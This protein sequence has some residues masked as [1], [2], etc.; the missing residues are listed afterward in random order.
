MTKR[1]ALARA[2]LDTNVILSALVFPGEVTAKLRHAWQS[3]RFVPLADSHTA[4]ELLRVLAYP[5]F[6]LTPADREALLADYLPWVEVI[7][8]SASADIHVASRD[9]DDDKF[10]HLATQGGA[11]A[12]VTGDQDLLVLS[13]RT[14]FA[15]MTPKQFIQQITN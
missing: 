9:P 8:S 7:E 3:G 11:N 5:K 13:E 14:K 12:L 2:V 6:K 15:I 1:R 10:L 4:A